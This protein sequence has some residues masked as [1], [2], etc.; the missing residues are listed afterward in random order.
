MK[1]GKKAIS[2]FM[3]LVFL[4][5]FTSAWA[6]AEEKGGYDASKVAYEGL[7]SYYSS[8]SGLENIGNKSRTDYKNREAFLLKNRDLIVDRIA[9]MNAAG[10]LGEAHHVFENLYE[11]KLAYHPYTKEKFQC[12]AKAYIDTR[13]GYRYIKNGQDSYAEYSKRGQYIRE[14]PN[15]LP[16]LT[17]SLRVMPIDGRSCYILYEKYRDGKK[18]YMSLPADEEHPKN[19]WEAENVLTASS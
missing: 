11:S 14:V 18:V 6:G 7:V 3:G 15:D 19:G 13:T 8:M 2:L 17:R 10:H 9:R 16:L 12:S 5:I 4:I 1:K